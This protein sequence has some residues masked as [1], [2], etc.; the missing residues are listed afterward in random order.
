M[1]AM[2]NA[3]AGHL[4]VIDGSNMLHRAW[5]MGQP[6]QRKD[7]LEIGATHLF[8][9]MMMK[10]LR[11]MLSGRRPPT[12]LA[13]F[14]DPS[15]ENSWR[16]EVFP[17]YKAN[18][19]PM[20][21]ALAA[22]IPLMKEMCVAMGVAHATAERHE[23]DDMIAAYVEDGVA[24][25]DFCSVVSTDKD[26]MQLVRPGVMQLSTVQDRW[27]NEAAVEKKFGVRADQV[28]DYLA[29]AGD[30]IDGIP[31]APGIGPKSAQALLEEFGTIGSILRRSDEIKRPSWRRIV[32]E[33]REIIRMSRT[34]VS[35]DH[36]AAPRLLSEH[37]M[38][39]PTA[40]DAYE[41]LKSWRES[42]L[43]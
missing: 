4:C 39:A 9:Q 26:L 21:P 35:L 15:R 38:K 37:A 7:G 33:N 36:A 1:T 19:P 34:L 30:T 20:D 14:F 29:L 31:G 41:G 27:F 18:R 16:R 8:G 13:A 12:H 22:Q 23:A 17:D 25:G 28:G 6:R 43:A 5:A 42:M 24:R 40:F 2:E 3:D 10:L 11:R 32:T